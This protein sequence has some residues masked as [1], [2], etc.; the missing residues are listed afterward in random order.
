M[1]RKRIDLGILFGDGVEGLSKKLH[2]PSDEKIEASVNWDNGPEA[3]LKKPETNISPWRLVPIYIFISLIL[4][5]LFARAFK[6]QVIEGANFLNRSEGNHVLIKI[7][8]APRGV[9]YDRNGKVLVRNQPGFRIA[10]RKIDLPLDWQGP[11]G[12]IAQL[13]NLKKEDLIKEI[14]DSQQQ[15]I[16]LATEISN[17]QI[18]ALRTNE[19]KY[20]WLDIEIYPKREYV[21]GE[22]LAPLLGY[23]SE[24]SEEDLR[25]TQS[26]PYSAGDQVG[27]AGIEANFEK[28]LRGANGYE[29]I[30]VDSQGKRQG[31]LFETKA[32]AGG[33][34][35][36]TI[37]ADLQKFV[38]DTLSQTL[39]DKGGSGASAVV[40]DP[41][42]GEILALVSAPSYNN[43]VFSS[44]MTSEQFS[45]LIND[46]GHLLLNRPISSSFPPGSTFK[47]V[48]GA[49]GLESGVINKDT[50]INDTGFIQIGDITFNNWLWLD[51]QR[52]EG[53]INLVR[54]IARSNDTY[55]YRL[56]ELLGEERIAKAARDFGFGEKTGVELP[57]E[58]SGLVPDAKW[59]KEKFNQVWYPGETVNYAIGQGYLLTTPIQLNQMTATFANGGKIIKPTI[60][61]G[62]SGKVSKQDFIKPE[63]LKLIQEGMYQNTVGDGNVAYLFSNFKIK[64][65]G[66]TGS[67]ESGGENKSHS[68]YTAYAPFEQPKI[69]VTVMFER[70]GHGSEISAPIVK[71]IFNWYFK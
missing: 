68:W 52:T 54:A 1:K 25:Q 55:F 64:T 47:L 29:L 38:Y 16:T 35:T 31:V 59:K 50:K 51:H 19:Q 53:E 46:P 43:N 3:D 32:V 42:T 33:D 36:L 20:P 10:V 30:K 7:N 21:Y 40:T 45:A 70:A 48:V 58:T 65:A 22:G 13:L 23:T 2:L 14:K 26:T 24:A 39:K 6:L 11:I 63:T 67:A 18:I 37:D 61:R 71:S 66:K 17:E 69:S 56:G 15:S 8:H 28:Q 44:P 9:I 4:L 12:E 57:G 34:V 49:S 41:N 60:V 27:K 62:E 5:T